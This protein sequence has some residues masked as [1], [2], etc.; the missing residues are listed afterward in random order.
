[1]LIFIPPQ[2]SQLRS[3]KKNPLHTDDVAMQRSVWT[4][5]AWLQSLGYEFL[6]LSNHLSRI[7]LHV[8][9]MEFLAL[10][11]LSCRKWKQA[12]KVL[13]HELAHT[14]GIIKLMATYYKHNYT[15]YL[16]CWQQKPKHEYYLYFIIEGKPGK[17][18]R[19]FKYCPFYNNFFY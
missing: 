19:K 2:E 8:I 9:R 7:L 1:M 18:E 14:G 11:Q 6:C 3:T 13:R 5:S 15:N 12:C 4:V 17:K 16:C 10:R